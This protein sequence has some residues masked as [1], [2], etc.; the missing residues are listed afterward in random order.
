MTERTDEN[1]IIDQGSDK[2][3]LGQFFTPIEV[4]SFIYDVLKVMLSRDE[5]W[6][7]GKYPS[8]ID[9]ACGEG[10]FLKIAL[11]KEIT[12]PKYVFGIDIDEQAKQKWEKINL[13]KSFGSKAKLDVHFFHQN[14]L[15]PLPQKRLRYKKGGLDEYDLTVGNPPYGGV[16]LQEITPELQAALLKYDIWRRALKENRN[17]NGFL[18]FDKLPENLSK[19]QE[20]R[21][22]TLP[23][24]ILFVERFVQLTKSGGYIGI[25]IPDGV[26]ANVE[27]QY[28]RNW[29]F[30]KTKVKAIISL[31][32]ETFKSV[33]TTAKTSILFLQKLDEGE[34]PLPKQ[35]IFMAS[36]EYV[37]VN[38][39]GKNDLPVILQEFQ[40]FI[41]GKE[42]KEVHM[43]PHFTTIVEG[44]K[45]TLHRIDADYWN[46]KYEKLFREMEK[47][48][49]VK[50]LGSLVSKDALIMGDHVRKSRG[51]YL[52]PDFNYKYYDAVGFLETGYDYSDIETCC[53]K[54]YERLKRTEVE[55]HDILIA[56]SGVG[57]VGRVCLI[58]FEP[59]KSCTGAVFILRIV[60]P[61]PYFLTV[62]LKTKYGMSQIERPK[63]GVGTVNI[64]GS[65][66]F[67]FRIPIFPDSIQQRIE[68]EYKRMLKYHDLAIKAK[69]KGI[70][71]E[72]SPKKAEQDTEY[73]KN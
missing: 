71:K 68:I 17:S 67:S 11:D 23:I 4:V 61:N 47:N 16:G 65:D 26:L 55:K 25:I 12:R 29:L 15:F 20:E 63:V 5:K 57:A 73:Q 48:W 30:E 50:S 53:R 38:N 58:H 36:A 45:D 64:T 40:K 22:K 3:A 72:K 7:R 24:E 37:G 13:L 49:K 14:G 56:C 52:G 60:N 62:F 31:P 9:P 33:G 51:E 66:V 10:V 43:S 21:L 32:R 18:P 44:T 42:I 54:A 34:K 41:H 70:K 59:G 8:I 6:T 27:L 39:S 19:K 28:V 2:Q 69:V 1:M 46:P 35:E